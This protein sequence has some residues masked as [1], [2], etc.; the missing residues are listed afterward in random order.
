MPLLSHKK[1]SQNTEIGIWSIEEP[2]E[3]FEEKIS[4]HWKEIDQL[5]NLSDR[6]ALEWFASR[7]L[8]HIMSGRTKRGPCLKDVF[9]KPYLEGSDYHISF[10][11]SRNKAAAIASKNSS[12]ID[13]QITVPKI[14][15]IA[16]K[17]CSD[18]ETNYIESE[19]KIQFLHIIWGAKESIYKAY[20][21]RSVDFRK[22]ISIDVFKIENN[23]VHTTA[24]LIKEGAEASYDVVARLIEE[25]ILVYAVESK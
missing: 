15:R 23:V 3:F 22:E 19:Q 8:I 11:H 16:H 10:S 24:H 1:I 2:I 6:K 9:G 5:E 14:T 4:L 20:G 13:I 12:G 25:Y 17:F 7:Y 21:R 18:Y